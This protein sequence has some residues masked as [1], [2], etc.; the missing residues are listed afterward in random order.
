MNRFKILSLLVITLCFSA[1]TN[2]SALVITYSSEVNSFI[3]FDGAGNF[4][5]TPSAN[6]FHITSGTAAGL[7]GDMSGTFSIGAITTSGGMST[8]PV[9]GTG[10]FVIHDGS[11]DLTGTLVW[12]SIGQLGTF[13]GLNITGNV[14]LTG[15]T[16]SGSNADLL[17]MA[18]VGSGID[19][20][21]FQFTTT[22]SLA[23]LT[24]SSHDTSFSGSI[25][26]PDGGLTVATL[27]FALVSVE[28]FRRK[29]RK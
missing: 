16:Y 12:V 5:F 25:E 14:N 11:S 27:G 22:V 2:V 28:G 4:N 15:I 21:S 17:A 19:T 1:V 8:A 7:L 10:T 20:L 9:T 24:T 13:D 26:V 23:D 3:D 6:S 18:A 29:L